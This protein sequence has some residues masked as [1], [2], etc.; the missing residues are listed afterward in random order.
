MRALPRSSFRTAW[1]LVTN[2]L[3]L[4]GLLTGTPGS[5]PWWTRISNGL[6]A[7]A[8]SA[9]ILLECA[10]SA[11]AAPLNVAS[12]LYVPLF[13]VWGRMHDANPEEHPRESVFT[14]VLFVIPC[15]VIVAVNLFFYMPP[16]LR[17]RHAQDTKPS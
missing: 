15:L 7:V 13:W 17:L 9:G 8:L 12:F 6:T 4:Y 14:L 5:T 10:S 11:A 3:L 1:V 16:L 2:G